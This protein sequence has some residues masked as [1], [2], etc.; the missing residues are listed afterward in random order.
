MSETTKLDLEALEALANAATPGPWSV[1]I[2]AVWAGTDDLVASGFD[3]SN[4]AGSVDLVGRVFYVSNASFI[5][6]AREAVPALIARVRELEEENAR[7]ST[8]DTAMIQTKGGT[9]SRD[10]PVGCALAVA[11]IESLKLPRT[12]DVETYRYCATVKVFVTRDA[13]GNLTAELIQPDAGGPK[14]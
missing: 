9:Y 1:E 12:L 8:P 7:L 5:A 13:S 6:A 10:T 3:D 14:P 11:A 4:A 2:G